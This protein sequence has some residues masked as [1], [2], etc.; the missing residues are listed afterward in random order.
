MRRLGSIKR[1]SGEFKERGVWKVWHIV[2]LFNFPACLVSTDTIMAFEFEAYDSFDLQEQ[3]TQAV[4]LHIPDTMKSW[5]WVR[6]VHPLDEEISAES[7]A[8]LSQFRHL[9][10]RGWDY[11]DVLI[12]T[13]SGTESSVTHNI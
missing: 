5:P 8:W 4:M 12:K 2:S 3:Q 13:D 7:I 10:N 9:T 6:M 1:F 11:T